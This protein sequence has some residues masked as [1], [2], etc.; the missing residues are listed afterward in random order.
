[1]THKNT[2]E[3]TRL[4]Y[5]NG[6]LV[7]E[8]LVS[9]DIC[10]GM[11]KEYSG[12]EPISLEL[13]RSIED[14][15][16]MHSVLDKILSHTGFPHL[17]WDCNFSSKKA[18][19]ANLS[20]TWH[21]DNHYN[22]WTPKLMIYLNSQQENSGATQFVD[23]ELSRK[24]SEM[25]GY[26]GLVFQRENYTDLV[27]SL[28]ERL[29]IDPVTLD[30]QNYTFSP[31]QAGSGVWFCPSRTLHRGVSPKKGVRHVLTFSLTPLPDDC[32]W[33][34][35]QCAKRSVEIMKDKIRNGM[36]LTDMNP[37]WSNKEFD[38]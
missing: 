11:I 6:F 4:L 37:Y 29:A 30:P 20:D 27:K 12:E 35:T 19:T 22:E 16:I 8:D 28:V 13:I 34:V 38:S 17:I 14:L 3:E 2:V 24:I 9:P 33:S 32:E 36:Q 7:E 5:K 18:N 10:S 23:A 21:Y 25:S 31:M 1:M 26:M 15:G